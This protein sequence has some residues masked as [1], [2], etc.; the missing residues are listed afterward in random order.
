M[1]IRGT[2]DGNEGGQDENV[3]IGVKIMNKKCGEG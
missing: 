2:G 3:R 1:K